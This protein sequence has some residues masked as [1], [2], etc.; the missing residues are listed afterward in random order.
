MWLFESISNATPQF[1]HTT[2]MAWRFETNKRLGPYNSIFLSNPICTGPVSHLP[3][4]G[5]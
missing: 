1:T 2:D 4:A 3:Q 5:R